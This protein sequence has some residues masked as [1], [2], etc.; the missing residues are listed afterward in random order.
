MAKV[1]TYVMG[2]RLVKNEI[3]LGAQY[4]ALAMANG[5]LTHDVDGGRVGDALY[6]I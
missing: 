3:R 6:Y 1:C 2:R 5:N 4:G